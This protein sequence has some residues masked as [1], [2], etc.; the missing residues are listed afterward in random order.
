M[1]YAND[2]ECV[3]KSIVEP[4][5]R[6]LAVH[7]DIPYSKAAA[8]LL[9]MTAAHESAGFRYMRQIKGPAKSMWQIE[10]ATFRSHLVWVGERIGLQARLRL[11]AFSQ[12][13]ADW[14]FEY[15]FN[16]ELACAFARVHYRRVPTALPAFGDMD[17]MGTYAKKYYNTAAGKA[18]AAEYVRDYRLYCTG[19]SYAEG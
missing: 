3:L 19:L 5:L 14:E 4:T 10:P 11:M 2:A 15:T 1:T 12:T 8:Q 18:T 7:G 9:M 6:H 16:Q 13:P 17:A